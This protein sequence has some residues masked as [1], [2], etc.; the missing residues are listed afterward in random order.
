MLF[1]AAA[2]YGAQRYG[3]PLGTTNPI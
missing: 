2:H 3:L 1:V